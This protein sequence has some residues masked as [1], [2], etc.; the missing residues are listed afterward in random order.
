MSAYDKCPRCLHD[1][2]GLPCGDTRCL[3]QSAYTPPEE[4][5]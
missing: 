3:C 2:H 1:W 5:Q 4:D